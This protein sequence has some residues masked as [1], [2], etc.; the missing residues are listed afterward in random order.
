M[1]I[2]CKLANQGNVANEV[3]TEQIVYEAATTPFY[4]ATP[5]NE[6]TAHLRRS[7]NSNYTSYVQYRGSIPVFWAQDTT[8]THVKPPIESMLLA[9]FIIS[10]VLF[11]IFLIVTVVDPF[12]TAASRH[13]DNLFARYG[14]PVMILNL[15]KVL[16]CFFTSLLFT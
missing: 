3:E 14:T 11:D 10:W 5:R 1:T 12:Y 15:I 8:A 2:Y 13:F 16:P 6:F 7:P 4:R 9:R